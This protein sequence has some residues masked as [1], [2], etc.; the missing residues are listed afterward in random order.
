M[1]GDVEL[2]RFK[3]EIKIEDYAATLGYFRDAYGSGKRFTVLRHPD[4]DKVLVT[5]GSDGHGVFRS[6]RVDGRS[7]SIVDFVQ[8]QSGCS[9]GRARKALRAFLG[10]TPS[11]SILPK[12]NPAEIPTLVEPP[13][14]AYQET[15]KV[16]N[17]ATWNPAPAYLL[18]RGL[19]P[20]TLADPIFRD[21][22]RVDRNGNVLFPHHDTGG[23]CGYERRGPDC[24]R[25]G[26]DVNRGLWRSANLWS[27]TTTEIVICE[28]PIDAM[29][30]YQLYGGSLAYVATGG[31][32]GQR[33]LDLL[34]LLF[35]RVIRSDRVWITVGSDNDYAGEKMYEQIQQIAPMKV[36]R[37]TPIGKDWNADLAWC[38][39]ENE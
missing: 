34:G 23:M 37:L 9:L 28:A 20:A 31:S 22:Y 1:I 18:S 8:R 25:F 32:L 12:T 29:S 4:G 36:H 38:N 26:K 24:K 15:R 19:A 5:V 27:A 35:K 14:D 17:A 21:C 16:W 7:G 30:H 39:R 33:Q 13:T 10:K 6:E 2:D 3:T 11:S